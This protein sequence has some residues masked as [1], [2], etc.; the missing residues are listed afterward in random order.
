GGDFSGV[1]LF[2]GGDDSSIADGF[3]DRLTFSGVSGAVTSSSVVN[4]EALVLSGSSTVSFT[5]DF[6]APPSLGVFGG[7]TFTVNGNLTSG[8][9]VNMQ[10]GLATDSIVVTG[11][12]SGSGKL[13]VDV[14]L[15]NDSADE[16]NIGG[17]VA[18]TPTTVSA[19]GFG[20]ATGSDILLVAVTGTTNPG[21][22]VLDGLPIGAYS[23]DLDLIGSSWYL[24]NPVLTAYT[25]IY[26]SYPQILASLNTLGSL[27]QRVGNRYWWYGPDSGASSHGSGEAGYDG[28]SS[29]DSNAI[30]AR[31]EGAHSHVEP[32]RSTTSAQY[33]VDTWKLQAG[34]DWLLKEDGAGRLIGGINA[35]YG[36]ASADIY[37]TFG[38]GFIQTSGY[39]VGAALT[40]I[41]NSGL[42]VDGQAQLS[43]FDSDLTSATLGTL[44][45]GNNGSGHALSVE[46]GKRFE[47]PGLTYTP[48]AQLTYSS[49]DFDSFTTSFATVSPVDGDSLKVRIGISGEHQYDWTGEDGMHNHGRVHAIA[50]L[51]HE[52]LDGTAVNVSGVQLSSQLDGWSGEVG[53]G[54]SI[55]NAGENVTLFGEATVTSSLE[56]FAQSYSMKGITGIR[57]SF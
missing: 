8:G 5:G 3:I 14:D 12:Y 23:F 13:Y 39:G 2:D 49:V 33:D 34:T 35:H 15:A 21:D 46:V 29:T 17:N 1:T 37:S 18:G 7:S 31:I 45:N 57:I 52:F 26:E 4:W 54:G 48:Q 6:V 24:T 32:D 10:D 38:N 42:Y 41:G 20:T 47:N 43:R 28:N 30:W 53:I 50:N 44:V 40:W 11:N 19:R 36:T 55:S 16:L 51:Y 56:N 9:Y 27:Q 22:F 25:A